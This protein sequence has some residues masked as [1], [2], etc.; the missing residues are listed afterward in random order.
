MEASEE[1]GDLSENAIKTL[2]WGIVSREYDDDA[3]LVE[4]NGVFN[5]ASSISSSLSSND[6]VGDGLG[7]SPVSDDKRNRILR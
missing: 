5:D 1:E 6:V 3:H 4:N 2:T 7:P